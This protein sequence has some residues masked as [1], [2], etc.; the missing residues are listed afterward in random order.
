MFFL[1][2]PPCSA[3]SGL[4][5]V[6]LLFFPSLSLSSCEWLEVTTHSDQHRLSFGAQ[7]LKD[8]ICVL[9]NSQANPQLAQGSQRD[10]T[11]DQ[12]TDSIFLG[13]STPVTLR[14]DQARP[15]RTLGPLQELL[16]SFL[17]TQACLFK[18]IS[19]LPLLGLPRSEVVFSTNRVSP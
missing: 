17:S 12:G 10:L 19:P 14:A 2:L 11:A 1:R 4:P 5:M 7:L 3:P 16:A 13:P 6:L 15:L 9:R 18:N 8:R